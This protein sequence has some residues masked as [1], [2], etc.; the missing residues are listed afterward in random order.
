MELLTIQ[1]ASTIFDRFERTRT[2]YGDIPSLISSIRENG[3]IQPIL[4]TRGLEGRL[5]LVAGGRRRKACIEGKMPIHAVVKESCSDIELRTLELEENVRRKDLSWDEQAKAVK[6]LDELKRK[7]HG[8]KGPG[9]SGTGWNAEKTAEVTGTTSSRVR[10]Q[11]TLA[12]AVEKMPELK[13][14]KNENDA[15]KMLKK[16]EEKLIVAE[17]AKRASADASSTLAEIIECFNVGDAFEWMGNIE[18]GIYH[19]ANVDTPYGVDLTKQKK[20]QTGVRTTDDYTEWS[21]EDFIPTFSVVAK[22]VYRL[23]RDDAWAV[24]WY[25]QEWYSEVCNALREAGFEID[26]IPAVWFGGT[27]GAQCIQPELY[28]A[29]AHE[30]FIV[31]RKGHPIMAK[32]GRVNVFCFDKVAPQAKIHPTEKPIELMQEIFEVFTVP[33]MR[34]VS[35]FL[36]S[37]NDVR[38]AWSK[39]RM[40]EGTD[41]DQTLK[42]KFTLRVENDNKAGLYKR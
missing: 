6:D 14:A 38:A 15:L 9:R 20:I 34:C 42:D 21:R 12:K 27:G 37:G 36:G 17:L 25:G 4:I 16:L 24:F 18:D 39:G 28:L 32:R 3:Q 10:Q 13:Q 29:R 41:L 1:D 7:V 35:P 22:E 11:I 40:C 2:D 5:E 31:A 19:F 33:G 26:K 30:V 23:L 8:S